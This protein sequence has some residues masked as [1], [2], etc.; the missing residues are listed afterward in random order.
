MQKFRAIFLGACC[1]LF[2]TSAFETVQAANGMNMIGYGARSIAMGGADLAITDSPFAMNINPA[3]IGQCLHSEITFGVGFMNPSVRH[4]DLLGN[5]DEDVLDRYPIPFLGYVHPVGDFTLGAGVFV[6]GGMGAEYQ[7]LFTPFAAMANSGLLPPTFFEGD[8]V[9][10]PDVM[11]SRVLFAK[12]TPTVAWRANPSWTL[13]A[14]LNIGYASANMRLFPNT[15]VVAD[16][17]HSGAPGDGPRDSFFGLDMQDAASFGFGLRLGFQYRTGKLALGGAYATETSLDMDGGTLDMNLSSLGLG[18]VAYDA[19]LSDFAWPSQL[20]VGFAYQ[21]IPSLL[22]AA[23]VDWVNWSG[24]IKTVTMEFENPDVPQAPP[25]GAIPFQMDWEDRW[26]L[27]IGAEIKPA[28]KW[29]VRLGFNHG[30]SPIPDSRVRP[31]FPAIAEDHITGGFGWTQGQWIL[32]FGLEYVLET[33]KTNNSPDRTINL[34]GPGSTE[35]LS[36]FMVHFVVRY[37]FS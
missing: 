28:E 20:G 12:F 7:N 37:G 2:M 9:P 18:T 27:A 1:V 21:L 34:F 25:S 24:A 3:G 19:K 17:D 23:D 30:A 6:Q 10:V 8:S 13:G 35:T 5:N 16:L 32:D 14:S 31:L 29:A 15:S 26:V 36:Q 33:S 11:R 22:I 4:S